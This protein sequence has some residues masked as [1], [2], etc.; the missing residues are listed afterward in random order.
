[1]NLKEFKE[2]KKR[3]FRSKRNQKIKIF[4][5]NIQITPY[6]NLKNI[7]IYKVEMYEEYLSPTYT[8]K[9]NKEVYFQKK[10]GKFRI[11]IEK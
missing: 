6:Q 10:D 11:I 7:P 1:M 8:F 2:Y 5:K 4:F 9:G 3:V